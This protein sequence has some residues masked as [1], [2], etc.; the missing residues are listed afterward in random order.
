MVELGHRTLP[1]R[2]ISFRSGPGVAGDHGYGEIAWPQSCAGSAG[3][4]GS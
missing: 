3:H 2:D 4:I 1:S